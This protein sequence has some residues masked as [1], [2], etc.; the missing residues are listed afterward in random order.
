LDTLVPTTPALVVGTGVDNGATESEATATTGVV[1]VNAETGSSTV[2]TFTRGTASVSKTVTGT[3]AAQAVVLTAGDVT[4]LGQGTVSV[5]AVAT[6][7]A[8]NAS[9]S[10]SSSFTLD[11]EAP[12]LLS[13][14]PADN[15]TNFAPANNLSFSF[16]EPVTAGVGNITLIN[17]TDN[18]SVS[19]PVSDAQV[20]FNGNTVTFNP[21][22]DLL[23]NKNY[24]VQFDN[25]AIR[26]AAGNAYAGISDNTTLN[27]SSKTYLAGQAEIDLGSY[28]K[29]IRPVQVEGNWYYYWDR[30][31]DG[32]PTDSGPLN[33]G[34]DYTTHHVLDGIFKQDINGIEGGG[35][36]TTDTYRYAT[37][38]GVRVALPTYGGP[39]DANG[40]ADP[41]NGIDSSQNGT[42]V[43]NN[44]TTDNPT[45]N[46]MLAIWDAFNGTAT[47][48]DN[49]GVP[50]SWGSFGNYWTAT[51]SDTGHAF[52]YLDLGY[53]F[54]NG[55][56][57]IGYVALQV[58]G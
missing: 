21:S 46:D 24:A 35:G 14:S 36:S 4:A 20:S 32:T 50:P 25:T 22:S 47:T 8:G 15:A 12:T 33:G 58:L 39:I 56:G 55:D 41:P 30:S 6:D 52:I 5:S 19:V 27:F 37:L 44:T 18:T 43:A 1:T 2:V 10:G 17:I 7:A 9:T 49:Y 48:T 53:V 57:G 45:Y 51:P 42:E 23:T 16:S 34:N 26:D 29:L 3:G 11:T 31:G 40:D 54:T 13:S 38:N 28:G